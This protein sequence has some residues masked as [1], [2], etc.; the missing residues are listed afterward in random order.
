MKVTDCP[1]LYIILSESIKRLPTYKERREY[2]L[3]NLLSVNYLLTAQE[4]SIKLGITEGEA[5]VL[6]RDLRIW[7]YEVEEE[8]VLSKYYRPRY[9]LAGLGGTFDNIHVGHLALLNIAFR[10]AE[11]VYIGCTSDELVHKL[12]KKGDV[13]CFEVRRKNLEEILRKY[14]WAERASINLLNDPYGPIINEPGFELLVVSPF[15]YNRG[16]EINELRIKNNLDPVNI[17][18]CPIVIAEDGKPVSSTRIR[19]GEIYSNGK[20]RRSQR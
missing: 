8:I 6:L 13:E 9:K 11:K 1:E 12:D 3:R 16:V 15:T 18:V 10:L 14:D 19:M 2:V 7:Y 5:L 17:E 4:L 20:V